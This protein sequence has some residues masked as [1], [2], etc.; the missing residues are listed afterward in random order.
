MKKI[1]LCLIF[2]ICAFSSLFAQTEPELKLP[3]LT[4]VIDSSSI[5][6]EELPLPEFDNVLV[7]VQDS[8]QIV[9]QL[10]EDV[11]LQNDD[12][13]LEKEDELQKSVY[14]EGQ[15]GGGY[16]TSF[17]GDFA[18]SS[19]YGVNPFKVTFNHE[20]ING[21]ANH[22]FS[23]G[24]NDS[25]TN[26][27]LDKTLVHNKMIWN[28]GGN[29]ENLQNGLQQQVEN[30]NS[31]N[32]NFVNGFANLNWLLPK[33]FEIG[34]KVYSN[35]YH[36][37]M[38]ITKTS[39]ADFSCPK[40]IE[41]NPVF[42]IQPNIFAKWKN[43]SFEV[44]FNATY[45]AERLFRTENS[46][47]QNNRGEF[48]LD[49]AWKNEYL[50]T[51]MNLGIVVGNLIGKNAI[52]VPFAAEVNANLPVYFSNRKLFFA[53][54][55][56]L[57]SNNNSI[58]ELE[59]LYNFTAI[60]KMP[61]ETTDWFGNLNI[62]IPIKNTFTANVALD[63]KK[64]AFGNSSYVPMFDSEL[65]NWGLFDFTTF[66]RTIF[67]SNLNI[68][69]HYKLFTFSGSWKANW[70]DVMPLENKQLLMFNVSFQNK[71]SRYGFDSSCALFLDGNDRTPFVDF[72]VFVQTTNSVRVTLATK[73]LLKLISAESRTYVAPYI[74]Q[75]GNV[76]LLIKFMF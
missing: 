13:V 65:P 50:T 62:S 73:D 38:D 46:V 27:S 16:P 61:S 55:G 31:V 17:I 21:Y 39:N 54:K 72:S 74:S 12:F 53:I 44:N 42:Y 34:S 68:I 75:G 58:Y 29:Y 5:I 70:L 19:L 71:T 28:F 67:A 49:F 14:V 63:F 41:Y 48:D 57:E 3:D 59:K 18:L 56:G 10:P 4:T 66:D 69:Y 7:Q 30:L 76:T 47:K 37:F 22:P 23:A 26:I 25:N 6:T 2:S 20:S 15:V 8:T 24:F 9:P 64:T 45:E 35:F 51:K 52:L 40:W 11:V 43:N 36:R 32:Q 60:S 1:K 33:G